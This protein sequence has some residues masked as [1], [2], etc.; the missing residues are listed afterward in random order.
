[1]TNWQL[2]VRQYQQ[3][4]STSANDAAQKELGQA[5]TLGGYK[6]HITCPGSNYYLHTNCGVAA[7]SSTSS[8]DMITATAG[9]AAVTCA[10]VRQ[11]TLVDA[12]VGVS[13]MVKLAGMSGHQCLPE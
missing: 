4:Q 12:M 10:V 2:L 11:V 8:F 9:N 13:S 6:T 5:D 1:M 3:H 7:E